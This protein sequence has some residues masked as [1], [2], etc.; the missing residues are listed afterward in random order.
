MSE[1]EKALRETIETLEEILTAALKEYEMSIKA[2]MSVTPKTD[3]KF[4]EFAYEKINH[5][6]RAISWVSSRPEFPL[7]R[8]NRKY[9]DSKI[10]NL[11]KD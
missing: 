1:E 2:M 5:I 8:Q 4:R 7:T 6:H 3:T 9:N 10:V 11:F